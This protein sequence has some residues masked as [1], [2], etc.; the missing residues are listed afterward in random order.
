[1][2][3]VNPGDAARANEAYRRVLCTTPDF[4]L[5]VMKLKAFQEIP[6]EKHR[7]ATQ[8]LGVEEGSCV[9]TMHFKKETK[10][11]LLHKGDAVVIWHKHKH[12]VVAGKD[13]A[14]LMTIYTTPQHA[15]TL[16]Q[17]NAED[18]E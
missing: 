9:V 11:T 15:A 3:R 2:F 16:V 8:F 10:D 18:K 12:R 14:L 6:M 17:E 7:E 13:G 5:V 1:M 4:Q